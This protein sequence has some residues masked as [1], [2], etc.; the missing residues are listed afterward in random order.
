MKVDQTLVDAAI[1][2][3]LQ[4]FPTG[5]AGAAAVYTKTGRIITS[6]CFE[7]PNVSVD[8]CHEAGA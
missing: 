6:V 1:T 7:S 3:A 4:R 5:Y 2:Q 8:L